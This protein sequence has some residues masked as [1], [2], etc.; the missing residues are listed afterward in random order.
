MTT[1]RLDMYRNFNNKTLS[2]E[3][4]IINDIVYST[5]DYMDN[6]DILAKSLKF[7]SQLK[8]EQ[9]KEIFI[10][11]MNGIKIKTIAKAYNIG[12][13]SIKSKIRRVREALKLY[14]KNEN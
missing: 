10:S 2:L 5:E 8:N 7:I 6:R 12:V 1:T 3:S 4:E 14:I 9:D 13:N 11:K